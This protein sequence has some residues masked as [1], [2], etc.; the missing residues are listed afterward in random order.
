MSKA[1]TE[2]KEAIRKEVRAIPQYVIEKLVMHLKKCS[3]LEIISNMFQTRKYEGNIKFTS[4]P[5]SGKMT[6]EFLQGGVDVLVL[7]NGHPSNT[8]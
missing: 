4:S 3:E 5:W 7:P 1:I 8:N 2:L 6:I